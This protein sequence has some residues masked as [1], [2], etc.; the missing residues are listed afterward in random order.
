MNRTAAGGQTGG[1]SGTIS[2][3]RRA[4]SLTYSVYEAIKQAIVNGRL[5]ANTRVTEAALA[6]QLVVSKTPVR[7]ALLRLKE[8]G[9]IE[10]EGPK[11]GGS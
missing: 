6:R 7:E 10:A 2:L 11:A 4:D 8:I 1:V 3:K 9:L 5:P